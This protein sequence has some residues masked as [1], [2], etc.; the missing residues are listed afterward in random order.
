MWQTTT[1]GEAT[2][3]EEAGVAAGGVTEEAGAVAVGPRVGVDVRPW[4]A[5]E[6]GWD[7]R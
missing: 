2:T 7:W 6:V 4:V 3:M 5:V 1:T